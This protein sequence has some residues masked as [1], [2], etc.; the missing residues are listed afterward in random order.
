M[1]GLPRSVDNHGVIATLETF[2]FP[3]LKGLSMYRTLSIT[4]FLAVSL[5]A[6]PAP[7]WH[8]VGHMLTTLV[9]YKQLSPGDTP[10]AAVQKLVAILKH[11]PRFQEDFAASLPKGLTA[12]GEA[13][14]LLCRA[15]VWPDQ[16]R[17]DRENEPSYPPQPAKQGSY[18]RGIWHYIDT[19][20]LIVAEGTGAEQIKALEEKARALQHLSTDVPAEEKDVTNA[21]QAIAF[22]RQRFAH[23]QPAEQ[24]VALC[25]LLHV[26]GDIHQPL[27]ASCGFSSVA[28]NPV[29]YPAG[30]KGG[31]AIQLG[32]HRNLHALWDAAP[33]A[34]P[35]AGH[36]PGEPFDERYQRAYSRALKQIDPLLADAGLNAQGKLAAREKDP[37]QWVRESFELAKDKVYVA[38]IRKQILAA[39][40]DPKRPEG[41]VQV[42]L[43]DGYRDRAHEIGKL[44]VV[45]G[46]YRTAEFLKGMSADQNPRAARTLPK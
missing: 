35:D 9:A 41:A 45:Q 20:L 2:L 22:N 39:D 36:D 24:A 21:L 18:H 14:W 1:P 37:K 8:E 29:A 43:P 26:L 28:L 11:H 16:I 44:R 34:A 13:R 17:M 27:H 32:E 15:S 33:D 7:A 25:W 23:G 42:Q 4:G 30:D 12:D 40:Q 19:P 6:S 31:N 10:S 3:T 46:G 5:A 38:E